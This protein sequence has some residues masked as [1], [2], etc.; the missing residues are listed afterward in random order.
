M[1]SHVCD[2]IKSDDDLASIRSKLHIA[3]R[4]LDE[5]REARR[6]LEKELVKADLQRVQL[7]AQVGRAQAEA[8]RATKTIDIIDKREA[9]WRT[10][11]DKLRADNDRLHEDQRH[12][13][14]REQML[15]D[16]FVSL[17]D[18]YRA[19]LKQ[20]KKQGV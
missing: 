20:H 15:A 16:D 8:D 13:H 4:A 11:N 1:P 19:L 9:V 17:E 3:L 12:W 14:K 5:S 6:R 2:P 10:S 18:A 7:E